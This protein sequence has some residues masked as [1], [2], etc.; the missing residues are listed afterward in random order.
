MEEFTSLNRKHDGALT[1]YW[2]TNSSGTLYIFYITASLSLAILI[3]YALS[4]KGRH[5][6]FSLFRRK[7]FPFLQLPPELRNQIYLDVID[8]DPYYPADPQQS[9]SFNPL[10]RFNRLRN[11]QR[12]SNWLLLANRQIH[13][14]YFAALGKT[15]TFTLTLHEYQYLNGPCLWDVPES[16]T[17]P[18]QRCHLR[19]VA[20]PSIIGFHDKMEEG[21]DNLAARVKTALNTSMPNLAHLTVHIHALTNP[22]MLWFNG[23]QAF[24]VVKGLPVQRI[25]WSSDC[26]TLWENHIARTENGGWEWRCPKGH[27]VTNALVEKQPIRGFCAA[28]YMEC[29]N[30]P[31]IS[32]NG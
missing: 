22:L 32:S 9:T 18:I 1:A 30:C 31:I 11:R 20:S 8:R 2:P 4:Y 21:A 6:I 26:K 15:T 10:Q 3:S 12:S 5:T 29:E 19:I 16:V 28:L 17:V 7:H 13:A 27:F 24:K 23:S 25:A 14:E